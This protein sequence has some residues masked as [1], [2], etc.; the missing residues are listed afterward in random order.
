[1]MT[2]S[3]TSSRSQFDSKR[4]SDGARWHRRYVNGFG[5]TVREEWPGF[6][7]LAQRR[8]DAEYDAKGRLVRGRP[9][10]PM[11]FKRMASIYESA[12]SNWGEAP[13]EAAQDEA[14]LWEPCYEEKK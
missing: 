13:F 1:M 14:C 12:V 6:G 4:I 11:V 3:I 2:T 5:E 8:R 9:W 7:E 10:G